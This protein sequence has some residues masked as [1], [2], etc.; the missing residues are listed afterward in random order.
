LPTR[1]FGSARRNSIS[2]GLGEIVGLC[3]EVVTRGSS[4]HHQAAAASVVAAGLAFAKLPDQRAAVAV[5][6]SDEAR[7][8]V[9]AEERKAAETDAARRAEQFRNAIGAK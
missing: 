6:R 3:A 2:R 4:R 5:C 8:H 1:V 9:A 7:G